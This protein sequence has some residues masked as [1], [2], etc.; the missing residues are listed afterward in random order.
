M[1]RQEAERMGRQAAERIGGITRPMRREAVG[2]VA[3]VWAARERS[4]Q[5]RE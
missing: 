3:A 1:G 4:E 5:E 2:S